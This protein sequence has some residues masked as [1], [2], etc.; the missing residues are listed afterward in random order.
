MK[1]M[2]GYGKA[3]QSAEGFQVN[4]E[5]KTVNSRYL[6]IFIRA[7]INVAAMENALRGL[8][9]KHMER[10]KVSLFVDIQQSGETPAE[11]LDTARLNQLYAQLQS[12]RKNTG[13]RDEVR[14]DHFLAFPELFEL[15]ID[16][17][18]HDHLRQ[19]ILET[20]EDALVQCNAMRGAEG[21]HLV[22]DISER[23]EHIKNH[24]AAIAEK[25]PDNVTRE[26]E[27]Y[28]SRIE[29]L[30]SEF[31][32]DDHRL[33]QEIA[34]ISDKVDISEEITRLNSHLKQLANTLAGSEAIGKRLTFILQE[35]LRETN[36]INSKTTDVTIS[37]LAIKIKEE[38]EK[39]RE[40]AQNLE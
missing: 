28:K 21:A 14:L 13:V 6:D 37:A 26:F 11:V 20:T 27:R 15:K 23:I 32:T 31:P 19:T 35:V 1:S 8:I 30:M 18:R 24:V 38:L 3:R 7:N 25:A 12:I 5:V 40:Q 39:I 16:F 33:E 29:R 17:D 9:K 36:T 22:K 34:L 10:G 4:V 2:T